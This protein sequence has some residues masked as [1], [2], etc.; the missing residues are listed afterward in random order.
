MQRIVGRASVGESNVTA[1]KRWLEREG[2]ALLAV[3]TGGEFGRR[4]A[5]EIPSGAAWVRLLKGG[6]R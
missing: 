4:L 6:A 2:I 1:A 3:E 5:F